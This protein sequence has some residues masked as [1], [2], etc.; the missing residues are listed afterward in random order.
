MKRLTVLCAVIL[1][2][3]LSVTLVVS[4]QQQPTPAPAAESEI[5]A[6]FSTYTSEGLFSISYPQGWAPVTSVIGEIEEES[7]DWVKSVDPEAEVEEIKLLFMAGMPIE[8]GYYP[9]VCIAAAP[10]SMGYY[11]LD[12]I[13]ESEG[14]WS[15]EYLQR[16]RVHSQVR[17]FV[18]GRE[19]DIISDEDYTPE[20][21][22]WR[23]ITLTMVKDDFVWFVTC[24]S[25][26]EDFN[27]YEDIFYSIVRSIRILK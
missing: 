12:E 27:D 15:R 23:Y 6:T 11:T 8:E 5:P 22:L 24:S 25:E 7:K 10:R 2:I 20:D 18:D 19:A 14:L 16:Y 3:L 21:G 4:C 17:T 9:S 1:L 26:S 13:V